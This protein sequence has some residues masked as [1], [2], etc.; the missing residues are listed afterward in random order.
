MQVYMH[1][2]KKIAAILSA[3]NHSGSIVSLLTGFGFPASHEPDSNRIPFFI[4]ASKELKKDHLLG[5]RCR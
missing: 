1:K 5:W 2:Q 4:R 3:V